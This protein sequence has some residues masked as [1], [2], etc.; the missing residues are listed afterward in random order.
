MTMMWNDDG[1]RWRM[2]DGYA[3]SGWLMLTL[4]ILLLAGLA[5]TLAV[6]LL[7]KPSAGPGPTPEG[8]AERILRRR[9][10]AGEIDADDFRQRMTALEE[11][12]T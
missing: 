12:R 11:H 2:H 8:E 10:A 3:G 1:D 7:R 9:F 4:M 5:V 6:V